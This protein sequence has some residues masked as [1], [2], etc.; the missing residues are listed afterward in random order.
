MPSSRR[1]TL[2]SRR[3]PTDESAYQLGGKFGMKRVLA[4][5]VSSVLLLLSLASVAVAGDQFYGCTENSWNGDTSRFILYENIASDT[6]DGND[7]LY[8]CNDIGDL[9]SVTH[10][11]AGTCKA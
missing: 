6:S 1:T 5:L 2:V 7:A 10:S 9:H 11:P 3:S 4:A 8:G